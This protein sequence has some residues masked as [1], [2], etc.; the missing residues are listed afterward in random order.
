[1][2]IEMWKRYLLCNVF[3]EGEAGAGAGAGEGDK[4]GENAGAG[5]DDKGGGEGGED[6]TP[7]QDGPEA[8][9]NVFQER[10]GELTRKRREAESAAA[11]EKAA[12]EKAEA[13]LAAALELIKAGNKGGDNKDP[14]ATA[15]PFNPQEWLKSEEG[16]KAIADAAKVQAEAQSISAKGDE[17]YDKGKAKHGEAWDKSLGTFKAFDGLREDVVNALLNV[18]NGEDVLFHLGNSPT[19]IARLYKIADRNPVAMAVEIARLSSKVSAPKQQSKAPS[20]PNNEDTGRGGRQAKDY[21]DP[22]M[23]MADFVSQRDADLKKR[24]VRL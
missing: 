16:K 10:I 21:T 15:K 18:D 19:E 7:S 20:P 14:P 5:D 9:E 22:N 24:G 4:G 2:L 8:R 23:S 13:D 1:M 6:K 17:L 3:R 11:T 12:R